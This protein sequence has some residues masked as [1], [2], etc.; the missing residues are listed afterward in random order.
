MHN[1]SPTFV[2]GATMRTMRTSCRGMR[3][4]LSRRQFVRRRRFSRA[5][6]RQLRHRK[7]SGARAPEIVRKG[8]LAMI[9]MGND[10]EVAN[11][12]VLGAH[13]APANEKSARGGLPP[14]VLLQARIHVCGRV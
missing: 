14:G 8:A 1:A 11:M 10:G 13:A 9:D 5:S 12:F 6:R 2:N 7:T 3:R 4:R